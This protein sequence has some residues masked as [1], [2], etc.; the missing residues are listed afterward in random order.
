VLRLRQ[1]CDYEVKCAESGIIYIDEIDRI[2]CK[3]E[4][5]SLTRDVSGKGVQQALLKLVEGAICNVQP[6]LLKFGLVPE[7]VGRLPVLTTL[8]DLDVL[9][10][11]CVLIEPRSALTKQYQAV[12]EIEGVELRFTDSAIKAVAHRAALMKTGRGCCVWS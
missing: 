2:S 12:F 6:N 9:A 3:S 11:I 7:F 5:P 8:S 4:N 1:G 10:L